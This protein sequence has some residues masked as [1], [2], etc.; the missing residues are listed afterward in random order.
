MDKEIE[1]ISLEVNGVIYTLTETFGM[2][3]INSGFDGPIK[4]IPNVSNQVDIGT[5]NNV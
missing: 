1:V 5:E 2:L 4:I 3:R